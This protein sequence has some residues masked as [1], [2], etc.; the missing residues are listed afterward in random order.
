MLHHQKSFEPIM[1]LVAEAQSRE[2]LS[3]CHQ[4]FDF[5]STTANILRGKLVCCTFSI[6]F[7]YLIFFAVALIISQ[8]FRP[9]E[10]CQKM[11]ITIQPDS[12]KLK[13]TAC[14]H[15]SKKKKGFY[16]W[17]ESIFKANKKA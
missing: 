8:N 12:V 2:N 15:I 5:F 4:V 9:W 1:S 10:F 11:L 6:G 7:F 3:A 13:R 14:K 17:I 16:R